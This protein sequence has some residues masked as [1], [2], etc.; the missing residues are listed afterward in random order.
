MPRRIACAAIASVASFVACGGA[1]NPLCCTEFKVGATID[2]NIGGSAQS[3]VAAQAVS[4]ISGIASAIVDDLTSA[5]RGIAQDLAAAQPDQVAAEA[6]TDK[7]KKAQAWCSLATRAIST[8]R[9]V[10][11]GS[12]SVDFA[13]PACEASVGAKGECQAKCSGSATCDVRANP[14]RCEGGTLTIACKGSC[15]AQGSQA[16]SCEGTCTGGCSGSCTAEDGV[17]C[18]GTCEGAC[19]VPTNADG[20]CSGVCKGTCAQ[21][22]PKVQCTGTCSGKCD[23]ACK[24]SASGSVKCDGSC[25]GDYEALSCT[26]GKLAGGCTVDPKCDANCNA[27]VQA[28]AACRPPVVVVRIV[29]AADVVAA[30]RLTSTLEAH[31]PTAIAIHARL[32]AVVSATESFAGNVSAVT[33]IK[34]ACIPLLVSATT[35]AV[36]Q[37]TLTVKSSSELVAAIQ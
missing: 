7:V 27:S 26:G 31:L 15:T 36:E 22:P 23:A 16:V 24:G 14:P 11:Q 3:Q 35:T 33:D 37:L 25:S 17:Q 4:D 6:N 9:F 19:S 29:G 28:K 21:T 2:A 32:E 18:A 5:C 20:S 13:P 34:A 1:S 30:G 12:V 8:A 10:V